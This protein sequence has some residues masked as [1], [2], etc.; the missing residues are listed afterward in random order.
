MAKEY[1][2]YRVVLSRDA[3]GNWLAIPGCHTW[4]ALRAEALKNA[5]EAIEGCLESLEETGDPVPESD[6]PVEV[7][8]V[9]ISRPAA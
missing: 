8:T 6:M 2:D 3:E 7:E 1:I 9:R 5:R 4:G